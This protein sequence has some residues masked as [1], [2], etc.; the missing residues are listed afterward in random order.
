MQLTDSEINDLREGGQ[1]WLLVMQEIKA[2]VKVG[3]NL[4]E[5]ERI[6]EATCQKLG[7][8]PSFKGYQGYPAATCLCVNAEIVHCIPKDYTLKDGDIITVDFGVYHK[9][10][11]V[12]GAFTWG[13]GSVSPQAKQLLHAIYTALLAG[14]DQVRVGNRI[15][16]ISTAVEKV[17]KAKGLVIFKQFVGHG[18]G[19]HLHEDILIPNYAIS[20]P[21]PLLKA[22]TAV[23]IEPIAGL[24]S[25]ATVIDS[26]NGWDTYARSGQ[27]VAEFEHTVLVTPQ[28]PEIIT[29]LESLFDGTKMVD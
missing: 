7:V 13:V 29:P 20:G 8:L 2:A 12:D 22:N 28:G 10:L 23:A 17:L 25:D 14:T 6:A 15:N 5:L 27:P 1:K 21:T 18:I 24:G 3:A 19:H 26:D 4:K 11:H 9:G 16:D